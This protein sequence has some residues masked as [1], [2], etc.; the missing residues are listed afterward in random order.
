[1]DGSKQAAPD[2]EEIDDRRSIIREGDPRRRA[3][4]RRTLLSGYIMLE[5][6]GHF[7]E[8]VVRNLSAT[9]ARLML[10][11]MTLVPSSFLVLI[12]KLSHASAAH[13]VWKRFP[14][15]GVRFVEYGAPDK[16][17]ALLSTLQR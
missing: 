15:L 11:D 12:P 5:D 6:D 1:M 13:V 4:R 16:L 14:D 7:I 9:G 17:S 10:K 8:V 3:V 2:A